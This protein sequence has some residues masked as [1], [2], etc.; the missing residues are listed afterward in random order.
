MKKNAIISENYENDGQALKFLLEK[1]FQRPTFEVVP[2]LKNRKGSNLSNLLKM[3][4]LLNTEIDRHSNIDFIIVAL[5]LDS[6]PSDEIN[7]KKK[8]RKM[9]LF[10]I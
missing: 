4:K 9:S 3:E 1:K 6:F 7:I 5:D 8:V 10:P 2:V